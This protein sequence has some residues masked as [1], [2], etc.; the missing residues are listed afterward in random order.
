MSLAAA[1]LLALVA[2]ASASD[3]EE[4]IRTAHG[5]Y[6][7]GRYEDSASGWRYLSNLSV[8]GANPEVNEAL[9]LREA[10][11]AETSIPLWAKASVAE[12][13]DGFIWNQRAWAE[14]S[15]G[16]LNEARAAFAKAVDRSSTTA[17]QAE[18]RLGTALVALA[19]S[20][21]R[22]ALAPLRQAAVAGP[23]AIAVA[24]QLTAE[25]SLALGDK[26]T[27]LTYLRQ[28]L[29]VDP[30]NLEALRSLT[31]LLDEIG[32]NRAAWRAARRLLALD[33]EDARARKILKRNATF[34]VGDPDS[35]SGARRIARPVL[36]ASAS[37]PPLPASN[38]TIRI[39]LFGAP[40]GRPAAMARCYI[41]VNSSFKVTSPSYGTLRD[42]GRAFDQL[43]IEHRPDTGVVEVR[44]ASRNILFV[45]KQPFRF[46]PE[47]AR[48][49]ILIKSAKINEPVGVD[50]GDREERG[51]LEVVPNPW[52]FRLVQEVPL[53]LYLYGAVSLAL[54]EGSPPEA[55]KAQAVAAR[56][57]AAWAM[58]HRPETLERFDALDDGSLQATVGVSGELRAAA[59]GVAATEGL[60]L[61]D[62]GQIAAVPQHEDSGGIT[63]EGR[64]SVESPNEGVASVWDAVKPMAPWRTPLDIERFIR[65][66]PAEGLFSQ[67]APTTPPASVRWA[68]VIDAED[69]RERVERR[70]T[71]GVLRRVRVAARTSTGRVK[72]L[73]ITGSRGS[74]VL[75]GR[76]EIASVL[77]PGSLR[78]TL[79][80]F[81]PLYDGRDLSRLL[82]WGAGSG[83]GLG[84]SRAGATGRAALGQSWKDILKAYFPRYA[85]RALEPTAPSAP[86]VA[87]PVVGPY[88]RTLNFRRPKK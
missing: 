8:V 37:E 77:S 20:K 26:Q 5:S 13:A 45:G 47:S 40:D 2:C 32:D 16:R 64:E 25:A 19:D 84:L 48:G 73:E 62:N 71:I 74:R 30:L 10:S 15:L 36:D 69:L 75:T 1:T 58:G 50:V 56:T 83:S 7:Q 65:D 14:L 42:D 35:A 87:K 6:L 38:K 88:K 31:K 61:V 24:A 3:V 63:E 81:Q 72:A 22:A 41:I 43:E 60:I 34:I 55:Y 67:A 17:T 52:G 86:A 11:A 76:E 51:I 23:F 21:P 4:A 12:G 54:P 29:E 57:S 82:V 70:K 39:G 78:S 79:M 68:R 49:S 53:E 80:V 46:V 44:D 85:L 27:A 9:S 28:A 18:A 66:A 33:P 59:A